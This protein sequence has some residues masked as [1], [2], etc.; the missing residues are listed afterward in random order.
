MESYQRKYLKGRAHRLKPVVLIGQGG[1]TAAV[2]GAI[3]VAL[4]DHELIKI[5]FND[6]REK[7]EKAKITAAIEKQTNA[8]WV[9]SIGHTVIFFRPHPDVEKRKIQLPHK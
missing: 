6:F 8:A 5:K 7:E 1:L 3:D 9:G 2:I 4:N